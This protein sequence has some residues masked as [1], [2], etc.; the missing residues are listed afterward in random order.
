MAGISQSSCEKQA[1]GHGSITTRVS[2]LDL[3]NE[4]YCSEKYTLP[5]NAPGGVIFYHYRRQRGFLCPCL[6]PFSCW[7]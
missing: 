6:V 4:I 7:P 1:Y 3:Q 2:T 5:R